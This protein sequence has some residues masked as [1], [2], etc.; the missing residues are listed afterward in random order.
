MD[1][2]KVLD[3]HCP[4][5]SAD[6]L[7]YDPTVNRFEDEC[8]KIIHD[9]SEFFSTWQLDA[10]KK[11]KENALMIDKTGGAWE[12]FYNNASPYGY[13]HHQCLKCSKR[14]GIFNLMKDW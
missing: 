6:T 1:A 2:K 10:W 13:C 9:L 12:V 11:T 5:D 14:C 4:P 8:G 3:D 7:W